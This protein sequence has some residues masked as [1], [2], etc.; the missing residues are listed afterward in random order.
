M[1]TSYKPFCGGIVGGICGTA[2][3]HP[4]DTVKTIVQESKNKSIIKCAK[5]LYF[6]NGIKGFYK[7]IA[8]PL[9]GIALEK[10]IVFGFYDNIKKIK[11]FDNYYGNVFTSGSIAGFMSTFI[12]TPIDRFKILLQNSKKIDFI[13]KEGIK[14]LYRGWT[15]TLY[16]EGFGYGLYFST[17]E[18][19][20]NNTTNFKPYHTMIYGGLSG[21][22]SWLFIYPID[23]VK[24]KMQNNNLPLVKTIKII[25]KENGAKGF[26]GG[27]SLALLRAIPLHIGVFSGYEFFMANLSH[28]F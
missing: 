3:S 13:K 24:T 23:P 12:V 16:R 27:M 10:C 20:K 14:G 28:S 18:L 25:A 1:D 9:L 6:N 26:Y 8:P 21:L 5:E 19:L 17:Y 7:G 22:V 2:L 11:P 4:F 15:T